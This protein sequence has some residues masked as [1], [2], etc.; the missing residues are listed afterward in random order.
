MNSIPDL[1]RLPPYLRTAVINYARD[2]SPGTA[3][4]LGA[5][6]AQSM[7]DNFM[8]KIYQPHFTAET[9]RFDNYGDV[10]AFLHRFA[11]PLSDMPRF[12]EDDYFLL[13]TRHL[14]EEVIELLQCHQR[15]DMEGTA[16]ALVDLVYFALGIAASMGLPWQ[17]LWDEVHRANMEK[18]RAL[19]D[20][21]DSRRGH[22]VDV[23]KPEGWRAPDH[24]AALRAA[25][26]GD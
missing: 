6:L 14:L 23:V 26:W 8:G 3:E 20:G 21:S 7:R 13:K 9:P 2:P 24:A 19:A 11:L 25:G 1:E 18:R 10:R 17:P 16:D 22:P 12:L 15:R 4:E 5:Q